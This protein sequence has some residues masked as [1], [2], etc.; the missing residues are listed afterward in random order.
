MPAATGS[1]LSIVIPAY[2]G[3]AALER[4][5][6]AVAAQVN[7][8]DQ[9]I[10]VDDGST[11]D[12]GAVARRFGATVVRM[13]QQSGPAAARNRGAAAATWPT[14]FFVD[15]DVV[16]RPGAID[17]GRAMMADPTVDGVIGSYD[18]GP[19]AATLVSRFKNLAHHYFHQRAAGRI[20]SFWGACG[21]LRR[22]VFDDA[23]GF[24]ERR[25][26]RPS[27][28]DVELGWRIV[29]RGG[30]LLLDPQLQVTHLKRWTLRSLVATDLFYRAIPWAR[31][32]LKR[33]R[34]A[35]ELNA[36]TVQRIASVVAVLFAASAFA[37]FFF[38]GARAAVAA[39]GAAALLIN[40][41]LF[42]LFWRKGGVR[43]FVAGVALQQL[44]YVCALTGLTIGVF[45][46]YWPSRRSTDAPPAR[47]EC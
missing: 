7:G 21:L 8:A 3:V 18:D 19:A 6:T 11:D 27:I 16:L 39:F 29:D 9:V 23:G 33:G 10:V 1:Q 46:H 22:E 5:L 2:N 42:R 25:F 31:W 14:L 43:L 26:S 30:H 41:P 13:D 37:A 15:S 4:C 20:G 28:E 38:G 35:G 24:D 36:S 17:R 32:S 47:V 12:I 44:Y 34:L 45:L 40:W